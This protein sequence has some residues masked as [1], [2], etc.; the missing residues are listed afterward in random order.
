MTFFIKDTQDWNSGEAWVRTPTGWRRAQELWRKTG[1]STW[2][3]R[4]QLDTTPPGQPVGIS[5]TVDS[6]RRQVT[7]VARMPGDEDVTGATLKYSSSTYPPTEE[8]SGYTYPD[9][10]LVNRKPAGPMQHVTW[11]WTPDRYNTTYYVSVWAVDE[12]GNSGDRRRWEFVIPSPQTP[13]PKPPTPPAPKPVK[14]TY[15]ASTSGT[16]D[17]VN[18][19]WNIDYYGNSVV[20]AGLYNHIGGW[21]YAGRLRSGLSGKTRITRMTV[22]IQRA[23]S[24]H[25]V[26]GPANVWLVPHR[27][28]SRGQ[29]RSPVLTNAA[30]PVN[31]GTLRR[32]QT[33]TFTVP[34][35]WWP[36]FLS[37][38]YRGLGLSYG[39]ATPWSSPHYVIAHGRGTT[40]GQV[41]V[42]AE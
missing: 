35:A 1:S 8:G 24:S 41:V 23:S 32:G 28:D 12:A 16:W 14:L 29:N 3:M 20:Q 42:E 39:S 13:P 27:L 2:S 33:G 21:F 4:K 19:F 38:N 6:A 25:G 5:L 9:G 30:S 15:N 10:D 31:V 18:G 37:G 36:H 34:T 40:S 26:S 22:R 17:R 7:V 11:T